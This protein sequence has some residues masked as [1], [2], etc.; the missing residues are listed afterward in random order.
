MVHADADGCVVLFADIEEGDEAVAYLLQLLCVLLVCI[1]QMLESAGGIHVVARIDAYLLHVLC[2]YVS[3]LRV[4]MNVG[5]QWNHVSVLAQ[6]GVDVH[7]ILRFLDALGRK[8][9]VF[10]SCIYNPFSLCH[11]GFRVLCGGVR[12]TLYAYRIGA[13]HRGGSNIYF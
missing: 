8:P 3:H 5:H 4:E 7:Q 10:A 11:A 2:R 12:H 1:F 13:A 9:H 6:C